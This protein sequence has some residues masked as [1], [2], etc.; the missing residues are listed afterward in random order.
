[1]LESISDLDEARR[2]F[3][4]VREQPDEQYWDRA[5]YHLGCIESQHGNP[6]AAR[7]HFAECLRRNR[8]HNQARRML[9]CSTLYRETEA[10][11]FEIVVSAAI[12]KVPFVICGGLRNNRYV[13]TAVDAL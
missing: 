3:K 9:N 13:S 12:P 1:Y 11:V 2:L 10:N 6:V 4:L 7:A 8:R 5:E